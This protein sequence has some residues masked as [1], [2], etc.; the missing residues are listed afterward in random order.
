MRLF[1]RLSPSGANFWTTILVASAK[2]ARD[3]LVSSLHT[4]ESNGLE[5]FTSMVDIGSSFYMKSKVYGAFPR[6]LFIV[7]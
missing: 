1:I 7:G 6:A 5:S 2:S 4:L 3:E